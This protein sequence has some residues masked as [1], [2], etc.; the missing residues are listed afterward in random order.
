MVLLQLRRKHLVGEEDVEQY[1]R[2]CDVQKRQKL[3]RSN[4]LKV[5]LLVGI[6]CT[7]L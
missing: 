5:V 7:A 4:F 3:I 2:K 6:P 1:L